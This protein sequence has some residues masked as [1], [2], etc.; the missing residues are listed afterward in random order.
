M[1][2]QFYQGMAAEDFAQAVDEI[3]YLGDME[4]N[5]DRMLDIGYEKIFTLEGNIRQNIP[6]VLVLLTASDCSSC[7]KPL[8]EVRN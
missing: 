4:A 3:A 5:I 7:E 8:R 6:K 1:I 2:Y